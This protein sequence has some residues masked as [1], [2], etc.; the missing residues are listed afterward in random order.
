MRDA[1]GG[2]FTIQIILF[3][4]VIINA[5]LAF[6]VNYTKAFRIKNNIV[7]IIEQQ[8]GFTSDGADS[9]AARIE[10]IMSDT[11]YN[12]EK[13]VIDKC[14][15]RDD[16]YVSIYNKAGGYCLKLNMNSD[17]TGGY[18]SIKTYISIN[19][20]ILN[21]LLPVFSDVFAIKGE[22]KT[23]YSNRLNDLVS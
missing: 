21:N 6:S 12:V 7:A 18:Y 22:T 17:G 11:G 1:I 13:N 9:A 23:I 8:E 5:Y 20:P 19:I 4:L 10:K 16:G 3:F 2:V 15:S 14:G